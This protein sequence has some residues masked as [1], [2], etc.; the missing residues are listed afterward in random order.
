MEE[1][2]MKKFNAYRLLLVL[3]FLA[4]IIAI[5]FL[6]PT[7]KTDFDSSK[8][9]YIKN[10]CLYIK[11]MIK[12]SEFNQQSLHQ[13]L[14]K[15]RPDILKQ[16]EGFNIHFEK[17]NEDVILYLCNQ[18]GYLKY[19]DFSKTPFEVDHTYLDN[20]IPCPFK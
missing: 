14:S 10:L 17:D 16:L 9:P 5:I 8:D 4:L 2:T 11:T 12:K 20:K 18:N 6:W 3:A 1:L 15:D 13:F 7:P 19:K